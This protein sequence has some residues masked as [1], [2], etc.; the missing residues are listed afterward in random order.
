MD[1][2]PDPLR[3]ERAELVARAER[4]RLWARLV[5]A[6]TDLLVAQLCPPTGEEGA[7]DEDLDDLAA[8]VLDVGG[9][10]GG[11]AAPQQDGRPYDRAEHLLALREARRALQRREE[12]LADRLGWST[13]RL[14][15]AGA[16]THD[17]SRRAGGGDARVLMIPRPRGSD[18]VGP[19]AAASVPSAP[20]GSPVALEGWH[21]P[22]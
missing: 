4:L 10:V 18:V 2:Q 11:D 5:R 20:A 17:G 14:V 1:G 15:L 22:A 6:R 7:V 19:S 21:T 13:A 12:A 3:R 16:P 8:L 9:G